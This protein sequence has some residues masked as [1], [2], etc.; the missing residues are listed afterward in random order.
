MS[1][2]TITVNEIQPLVLQIFGNRRITAITTDNTMVLTATE[3]DN[4]NQNTAMDKLCGMFKNTRL[5]S[6]DDFA[7]NKGI[8]K[9]LEERKFGYE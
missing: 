3:K 8:E 9:K 7:K 6:S 2:T 4:V 1:Y 5:L